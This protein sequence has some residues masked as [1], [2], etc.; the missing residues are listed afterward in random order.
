MVRLASGI[1]GFDGLVSGGFPADASV[2]LQGPPGQEKLAFALAFL[3]EGLRTGGSGLA[4]VASQSPESLLKT[5]RGLGVDV[6]LVLQENRLRIVDW[7]S[8]G[9]ETV[10]DVEERGAIFRSSVDLANAGAAVSRAIAGLAGEGPKRAIVEMLSPAMNVYELSQ[11][12]AFAQSTKR[13]FDRFHFTALFLLEKEM[14]TAPVLSTLHQPFDGVVEMERSRS[15]DRILRKIGILHLRDTRPVSDFLP[16][17]FTEQ[18]IHVGVRPPSP[19]PTSAITPALPSAPSPPRPRTLEGSPNRVRLIMEIARERL[20]ADPEDCDALFSLAAALATVDDPRDAVRALERLETINPN[21]PG[22]WAFEMKLFARLGDAERWQR[23]RKKALAESPAPDAVGSPPCPFC[24]EPV[25]PGSAQCPHCMADLREESDML[26]GLEKLV[27]ATV[28]ETVPEEPATKAPPPPPVPL[29]PVAKSPPLKPVPRS[30]GMTNGL[31]LER[32]PV[33]AGKGG[34]TNGLTNGL[35]GR[36]NGLTNGLRGRTNGLTNGLGRTNGLT[37]GVGRTNGLA[38]GLAKAAQARGLFARSPLPRWQRILLPAI[39]VVLLLLLP[40]ALFWTGP[41]PNYPIRIDGQFADWSSVSKIDAPPPARLNPDIDITRVAVRSNLDHTAFYLEVAGDPLAGG[42]APQRVTNAFFAFIDADR[43]PATGYEL[44]GLGADRMIRVDTWGGRAV[45]AT[46]HEFDATRDPH[47]WNGWVRVGPVAAAGSG[48]QLEFEARQVD[49]GSNAAVEVAFASRGWNGESDAADVIVTDASPFVLVGQDTAA[50]QTITGLGDVLAGLTLAA[51]DGPVTVAA[52]NVTLWGTFGAGSLSAVDLVDSAGTILSE[53]APGATVRFALAAFSIPAN[54]TRTLTVQ[55]KVGTPDGSTVGVFMASP[56]DVQTAAGGVAFVAPVSGPDSLAYVGVV[57]AGVWTDGGFAD[58]SNVT[59]DPVGD[60]QPIWDSDVDLSAYSFQGSSGSTYFTAQVVG[61]ALNG[62]M[63]P[64]LNPAY[65][66]PG[67]GSSNGT[68]GPPPPPVNGTD[69]LLFYLDKDGSSATG[70]QVGGMGAD[71]LIQIT[72]KGGN[73]VS[74][75]ALRFN[76]TSAWAWSWTPLGNAAAAKDGSR[77]EAAL[78]GVPITNISRAFFEVRGWNLAAD[79]SLAPAAP[80]TL[81][82]TALTMQSTEGPGSGTPGP[83]ALGFDRVVAQ[84][85]PGNQKWFFT[86]TAL[87]GGGAPTACSSNLAASTTAGSSPTSTTLTSGSTSLCWYTPT[88]T[89]ASTAAGSWEFNLDI[90]GATSTLTLLPN[91][92]GSNNAWAGS[93][94]T[95]GSEYLCVNQDPHDGNTTFIASGTGGG[96]KKSTFSLPDWASP[97]SPVNI[98]SVQITV[99][100][101]AATGSGQPAS[102]QTVLLNGSTEFDGTATVCST[103]P[104]AAVT[105]T[106]GQYPL[107]TPRSWTATDINNLQAGV[108]TS[109]NKQVKVTEVKVT[110]TYMPSYSVEIDL[111]SIQNC[112]SRTALYGPTKYTSFGNN[113]LIT[114]P[115]IPAQAVN[116]NG[117][118]RFAVAWVSGTSVTVNYNGPNPTPGTSDSRA[119]VPIPEFQDVVLP[120]LGAVVL[121]IV[122]PARRRRRLRAADDSEPHRDVPRH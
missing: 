122:L 35:G 72:G 71:Y 68:L 90:S 59:S 79:S 86:S 76:G 2:I 97:P 61:R 111:C 14:H 7:Y 38:K 89:P 4:V 6:D 36:T 41:S 69:Y 93:G 78:S 3:S 114:T 60:V 49:L 56:H 112:N 83:T 39:I 20:R 116:G 27:R 66:P 30:K 58:W 22:L 54:T 65:T 74:S 28:R 8:W 45:G 33:P 64:A 19:A 46:L 17:E 63:V 34:R 99:W 48:N 104:Y 75:T 92:Q 100:C 50:P 98:T 106:Y 108:L 120:V 70:Y 77:V 53:Q 25:S 40:I 62:T 29:R 87:S 42:L 110:V 31:I 80:A 73:I 21:Y 109:G 10:T 18:G 9:E 12:Y 13:K 119:T 11:V 32:R 5:L 16:F 121:T 82:L 26:H 67:N 94:C 52:L 1:E 91:A 107:A 15:E 113:I 101:W 105:T 55:G 85:L 115:S 43:S 117:R 37:N 103:G 23:S 51:V 81:G 84:D 47:D 57:R 95:A 88:G 118:I 24:H 44:Q 96:S 102:I